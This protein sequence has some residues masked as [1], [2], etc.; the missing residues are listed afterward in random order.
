MHREPSRPDNYNIY[1]SLK[2]IPSK[3]FDWVDLNEITH[4]WCKE[5]IEELSY[6]DAT[7][8]TDTRFKYDTTDGYNANIVQT[9][10]VLG[11]MGCTYSIFE[12]DRKE[13][14]SDIHS[15]SILTKNNIICGQSIEKTEVN[16]SGKVYCVTVPSG[17]ILVRR[18]RKTLVSGNSGIP[19]KIVP[20]CLDILWKHFGGVVNE[21]GYKVLNPKIRIIQGDGMNYKSIQSLYNH[22]EKL[23]WSADNLA[24]GSGGGLIQIMNRDT[25]KFAIKACG[26]LVGN[27]WIDIYKDPIT[28][29][30]KTSKLGRYKTVMR[31]NEIFSVPITYDAPGAVDLLETVFENGYMVRKCTLDDV[32]E[33]VKLTKNCK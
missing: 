32:K 14:F 7:R 12:D 2:K 18:N 1:I 19:E 4:I 16:Y 13:H 23:G 21:K 8:R 27:E 10:A 28:D 17:M 33:Q 22:L 20:E 25:L 9:V 31:N 24:V 6:W 3:L 29:P 30:G 26:A 5:F 15:L 11:G